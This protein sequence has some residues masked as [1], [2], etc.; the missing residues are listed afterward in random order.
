MVTLAFRREDRGKITDTKGVNTEIED[1]VNPVQIFLVIDGN[2]D[3]P[4][5]MITRRL[6]LHAL[7]VFRIRM[8]LDDLAVRETRGN[9]NDL[10]PSLIR[11]PIGQKININEGILVIS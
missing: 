8:K 7:N 4:P 6:L 10:S 2:V 9:G 1:L 3:Q 5:A 11:D